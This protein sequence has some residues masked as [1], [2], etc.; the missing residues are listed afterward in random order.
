MKSFITI[1][2]CT[3]YTV[4]FSQQ[5]EIGQPIPQ[6]ELTHVMNYPNNRLKL[7]EFKGKL[8]I[9]DFWGMKCSACISAFPKIDSI[10][11]KFGGQ[12]QIIAVNTESEDSTKTF[13]KKHP[14]IKLPGIPF[15]TQDKLLNR[16]FP[17]N[18]YPWHVWIDK[19]GVIRH[20]TQGYNA[21][22]E[23]IQAFLENKKLDIIDLRY[24]GTAEFRSSKIN[25]SLLQKASFYSLIVPYEPV[26]TITK[27][28]LTDSATN[29]LIGLSYHGVSVVQLFKLAFEQGGKYNFQL[30]NPG[31]TG[32]VILNIK[33]SFRYVFPSNP[34]QYDWWYTHYG[35]DYALKVPLNLSDQVFAIMQQDLVRYFRLNAKVE[36]RKVKCL[37]LEK[38]A[39]ENKIQTRGGIPATNF[40]RP[41]Q[42]DIYFVNQPFQTF[43]SFLNGLIDYQSLF[44]PFED[45]T[46]YQGNIDFS[47]KADDMPDLGAIK[48]NLLKYNLKLV[49]KEYVTNVLVLSDEKEMQTEYY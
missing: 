16:Y 17:N 38:I 40:G 13:F 41:N 37:V 23:N 36:R 19:D 47:I 6:L 39:G 27:S 1:V 15:V 10:Q 14:K 49:E 22:A 20:I 12:L 32:N 30:S 43:F 45:G 11:K 48:S 18:F 46:G 34:Q 35:Y 42:T 24:Q 9:L 31:Y 4:S 26:T 28:R 8:V 7:S 3:I 25:N 44:T 29:K 2:L 21:T 33:D 5:L